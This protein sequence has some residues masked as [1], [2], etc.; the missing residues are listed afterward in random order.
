MLLVDVFRCVNGRTK[1]GRA[2]VKKRGRKLKSKTHKENSPVGKAAVLAQAS[3]S[4][5]FNDAPVSAVAAAT[6]PPNSGYIKT[7]SS[8][9]SRN[10][11]SPLP[12]PIVYFMDPP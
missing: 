7:H 8:P 1:R 12:L 3:D 9:A 11:I 10:S 5:T 4:S 6:T 2:E